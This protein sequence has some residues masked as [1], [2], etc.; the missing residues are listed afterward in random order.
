MKRSIILAFLAL[1]LAATAQGRF[2]A[3]IF[4]GLNMAQIDGDDAGRYNHPGLRAGIG[5]S[6]DLGTA[7]RPVIELAYTQ[8]GSYVSQYDRRLSANYVEIAAM[9]SYNCFDDRL[10]LAAGVA[11]AVLVGAK[12]TDS[13]VIDRL[14]SDNFCKVDWIPVTFAARYRFTDHLCIDVRWQNSM[15]SVTKENGSGTYRIFRSNIG[16]FNRLVT[17]GL[18]WQF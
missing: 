2:D 7:W 1:A 18:A 12:V 5:T 9:M 8:K 15:L 10:R 13:G 6:I 11:P 14:S 16:A 17:F 4:A 3:S